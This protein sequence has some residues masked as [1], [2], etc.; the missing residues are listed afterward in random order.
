[1]PKGKSN[2]VLFNKE[3]MAILGEARDKLEALGL[4]CTFGPIEPLLEG[5][6]T[7]VGLTVS[8]SIRTIND[9]LAG[10]ILLNLYV[11]SE[12]GVKHLKEVIATYELGEGENPSA[13][14]V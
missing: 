14:N 3:A 8:T 5:R 9:N 13:E 1:M 2:N 10:D 12:Q 11:G 4:H 7:A 6:E